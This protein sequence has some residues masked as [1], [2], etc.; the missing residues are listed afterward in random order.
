[1]KSL[2]IWLVHLPSRVAGCSIAAGLVATPGRRW[3]AAGL[4]AVAAAG[5]SLV[6]APQAS[7]LVMSLPLAVLAMLT[8]G[9][10]V[11][12]RKGLSRWASAGEPDAGDPWSSPDPGDAA[13]V[14]DDDAVPAAA[15]AAEVARPTPAAPPRP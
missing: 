12:V 15:P 4:A 13:P 1:M 9:L 7:D 14:A 2:E 6:I 10:G 5:A 8:M 11:L 3:I